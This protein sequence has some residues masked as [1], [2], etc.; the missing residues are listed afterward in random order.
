MSM[1]FNG[2][3]AAWVAIATAVGIASA[4]LWLYIGWR[5]MRAHERLASAAEQ[6]ARS[7]RAP[8][9]LV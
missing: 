3:D 9:A 8:S 5:A 4:L 2:A 1:S 7:S 6:I